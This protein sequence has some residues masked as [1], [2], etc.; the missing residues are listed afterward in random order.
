MI[1][2]RIKV[3]LDGLFIQEFP[4]LGVHKVLLEFAGKNQAQGAQEEVRISLTAEARD[5]TSS[6]VRGAPIFV[7]LEV[8][9]NGVSFEGRMIN[10]Q[11]ATDEWLIKALNTDAFKNGLSLL[12]SAQ[13][14]LRPFTTL[15]ADAVAAVVEHRRNKQIFAFNLGLDFSHNASA[16]R[17]RFG[18]YIIVQTDD[19]TWSWA[20]VR[21]DRESNVV[22]TSGGTPLAF[23]H[24]VI[25]ISPTCCE[26]G[27]TFEPRPREQQELE[28]TGRCLD[29]SLGLK[30]SS[31]FSA[32]RP[33]KRTIDFVCPAP[34]QRH[35]TSTA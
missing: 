24:S 15:A 13:P 8:G 26:C 27:H 33:S 14:V 3:A 31:W 16:T 10:V 22:V 9:A 17:L 29:R 21:L 5:G 18:S 32:H 1:G 2:R 12:N 20:D 23:N 25:G 6:A 4:G 11:S 28:C 7:N 35:V 30:R 19:V 34:S